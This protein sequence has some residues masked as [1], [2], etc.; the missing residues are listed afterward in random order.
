MVT[1][2]SGSSSHLGAWRNRDGYSPLEDELGSNCLRICL[3][4][5]KCPGRVYTGRLMQVGDGVGFSLSCDP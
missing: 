3:L 1:P 2:G 4:M 5:V